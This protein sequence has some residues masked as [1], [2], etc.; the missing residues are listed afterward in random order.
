MHTYAWHSQKKR[1]GMRRIAV[2]GLSLTYWVVLF[3]TLCGLLR[4]VHRSTYLCVLYVRERA[5][6]PA[7]EAMQNGKE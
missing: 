2:C 3:D 6:A 7:N 4:L 1:D 5:R